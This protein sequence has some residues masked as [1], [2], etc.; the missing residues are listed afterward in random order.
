MIE[1]AITFLLLAA[2]MAGCESSHAPEQRDTP[3]SIGQA[4]MRD[5]GT[6]VLQLR[7]ENEDG[8]IGDALLIY[9]TTH[10]RYQA[11]RAHL[12]DLRPGKPTAVPP[13]P[14]PKDP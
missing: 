14:A 13:F 1:R 2:C 7:A 11:I 3:A 8:T 12:P 5:D 9:P 6:I 10:P 4:S